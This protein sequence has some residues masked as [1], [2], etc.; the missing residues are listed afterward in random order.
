MG[1]GY[2]SLFFDDARVPLPQ[3][4]LK[5]AKDSIFKNYKTVFKKPNLKD[6]ENLQDQ[7]ENK[8][9]KEMEEEL[10]E[11]NSLGEKDKKNPIEYWELTVGKGMSV[12]K[13]KNLSMLEKINKTNKL[14]ESYQNQIAKAINRSNGKISEELMREL[15]T[16]Q[17]AMEKAGKTFSNF[18]SSTD[19]KTFKKAFFGT[20]KGA[21]ANAQGAM[22]EVASIL[23]ANSAKE[24]VEEELHKYNKQYE[25]II[26]ATGGKFKE[27][28]ELA[29]AINASNLET[30]LKNNPKND[31]TIAVKD[32]NGKIVWSSG[33]SLKSVSSKEPAA[34]KI[35]EQ[36]L[37][38]LLNK[39]YTQNTYLNVAAGLGKGDWANTRKGI[40]AL[41]KELKKDI[42]T[43]GQ[44][45][46]EGW[47]NMV[48]NAIYLQ[49]IDMFSGKNSGGVLNNAQY[50]IIASKPISMYEIFE[51][52]ES[53]NNPNAL[54]S[55]RGIKIEGAGKKAEQYRKNA[56]LINI[57]N[58]IK[59]VD[60][61]PYT[62][63]QERILRSS[64]SWM[65]VYQELQKQKIKISLKYKDLIGGYVR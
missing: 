34:V 44:Q 25:L 10:R 49:I 27:D 24:K 50:L 60:D 40:G 61:N 21:I 39:I 5:E 17:N 36:Y 42:N 58:F 29:K 13:D 43:T 63:A 54:T 37:T 52:I 7:I 18:N 1:K 12:I 9:L 15:K 65:Q 55:I 53:V 57:N 30:G 31:I 2:I 51:K 32:G 8:I 22:H 47:K 11:A 3:E 26:E 16:A 45:L 64:A 35:M 14:I 6:K 46:V 41:A 62:T 48:Y 20:L 33:I 59:D 4:N 23:A 28:G 56:S 38:T 19:W